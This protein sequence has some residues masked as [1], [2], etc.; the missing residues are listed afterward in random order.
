VQTYIERIGTSSLDDRVRVGVADAKKE[1][2]DS[3]VKPPRQPPR[4]TIDEMFD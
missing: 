1:N 2:D 4:V 3:N